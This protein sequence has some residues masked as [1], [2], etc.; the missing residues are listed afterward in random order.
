MQRNESYF[1]GW[2]G[3]REKSGGLLFN[4]GIHYLDLLEYIFG[5]HTYARTNYLD[6]KVGYGGIRG[7]N[8]LCTWRIEINNAL[9]QHRIFKVN[10]ESYDFSNKDNLSQ[11][12][13]HKFVYRDLIVG[14]GV[15]PSEC[16]N[17]VKLVE[18]LNEYDLETRIK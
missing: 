14:K 17:S 4:L 10:G 16:V 15:K 6:N 12:D 8:Y 3:Q 9:S 11:E 7:E 1:Q 2:K 5:K 18:K 13:L